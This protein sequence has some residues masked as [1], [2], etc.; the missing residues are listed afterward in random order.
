MRRGFGEAVKS[1]GAS[2]QRGS[3]RSSALAAW[4]LAPAGGQLA[5]T[6]RA[7]WKLA[8]KPQEREENNTGKTSWSLMV[9]CSDLGLGPWPPR[10]PP[11][12]PWGPAAGPQPPRV[13]PTPHSLRSAM[14][15]SC[16][17]S[18]ITEHPLRPRH[19]G[20]REHAGVRGGSPR[21]SLL[22]HPLQQQCPLRTEGRGGG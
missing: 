2:G 21:P 12:L 7:E 6:W 4:S 11:S 14:P 8:V 16:G 18:P 9:G 17:S 13:S 5:Y 1:G 3:I 19:H 20:G 15:G 10:P 22:R